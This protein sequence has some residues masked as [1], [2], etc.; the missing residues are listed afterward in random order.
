MA[1]LWFGVMLIAGPV[2]SAQNVHIDT[3]QTGILTNQPSSRV[4]WHM[5][6]NHN[7]V[8]LT[9]DDGPDDTITPELL[10]VLREKNVQA[11]FFLVGNMIAKFPHILQQ[12]ITD[13]HAIGN[14]TWAHYRLDEMSQDQVN[15]QLSAT[16]KAVQQLHPTPIVYVRPPGGRF[17]NFLIH[18]AKK[19]QLTVVM[20]DVNAADYKQP[21]GTL[22]SPQHIHARVMRRIKPGSIVLMHNSKATVAALPGIIDAI[23]AKGYGI[24]LLQW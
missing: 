5:P 15:L 17:N 8:A 1:L 2:F 14:H 9:F 7:H 4:M 21:D 20:W 11:T 3:Q 10:T 6:R 13:G 16:T 18:A 22:P 23:R 12:I 19:Q 24:G